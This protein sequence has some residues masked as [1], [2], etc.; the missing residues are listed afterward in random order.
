MAAKKLR[1]ARRELIPT[2]G[3]WRVPGGYV[4][5]VPVYTS[6]DLTQS[7]EHWS[8]V[9]ERANAQKGIV[10]NY[11][12]KIAPSNV[13]CV[14]IT[15]IAPRKLDSD[16]LHGALK[17]VRDAIALALGRDDAD[18][19]DGAIKWQVYQRYE[20]PRTYGIEVDILCDLPSDEESSSLQT[21]TTPAGK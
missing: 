1:K 6:S 18:W 17:S 7:R 13:R 10:C 14:M 3:A 11:M 21:T 9:R 16:N 19:K 2:V 15:R 12:N 4:L 20:V 5:R 8:I